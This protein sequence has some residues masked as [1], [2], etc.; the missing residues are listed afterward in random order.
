[1]NLQSKVAVVTGGGSG[2][3][4]ATCVRLAA[5]GA[6]VAVLDLDESSAALTAKLAGDGIAVK[7]GVADSAHD[8]RALVDDREELR[9]VGILVYNTGIPGA[10]PRVNQH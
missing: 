2:I 7:V 6:R 9:P 1:M 3:G 10:A 5:D 4:E 8:Q